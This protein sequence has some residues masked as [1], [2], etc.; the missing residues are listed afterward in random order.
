MKREIRFNETRIFFRVGPVE[1]LRCPAG[2]VV[3]HF[4]V[5]ILAEDEP[6]KYRRF[7]SWRSTSASGHEQ[8]TGTSPLYAL[9]EAL[10]QASRDG[11]LGESEV[12]G[13]VSLLL[14]TLILILSRWLLSVSRFRAA[15]RPL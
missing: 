10:H 15:L 9:R 14:W 8:D 1:H 2:S 4:R 11:I 5:V 13:I 6:T 12:I 3:R 7:L